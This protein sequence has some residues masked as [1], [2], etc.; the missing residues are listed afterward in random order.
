MKNLEI[1]LMITLG[2]MELLGVSSNEKETKKSPK[3]I[4]VSSNLKKGIT[5][6]QSPS[7]QGGLCHL[8]SL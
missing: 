6:R 3:E 4:P 2:V 5:L 8:V 1:R 7:N